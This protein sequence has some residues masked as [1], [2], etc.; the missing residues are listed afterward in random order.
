MIVKDKAF[1][2]FIDEEQLAQGIEKLANQINKDYEGKEPIFL[3]ILNGSFMFAADLYRLTN[4]KSTISFLKLASYE[5][6]NSTG[7][8]KQLVGLQ[9]DLNGREVII[10][11]DIVDTGNTLE[12]I[13]KLL[14]EEGVK[15]AE[16]ASLLYKPEAYKKDMP[17]KYAAFEIPNKFVVG[18]GLDYD[19]YGRNLPAVYQLAE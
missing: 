11:E 9:D 13:M 7:E 1:K 12:H 17:I 16:I 3:A 18:Y 15:S 19:G 8:V 4:L 2:M 14:K 10:I 5:S 6:M